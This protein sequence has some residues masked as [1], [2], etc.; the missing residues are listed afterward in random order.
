MK[1]T[2]GLGLILGFLFTI[3]SIV[4]SAKTSNN[5]TPITEGQQIKTLI[6]NANVSI[7]L[8]AN[9]KSSLEVIGGNYIKKHIS[10][11]QNGDTLVIGSTRNKNLKNS[12][13]IYVPASFLQN[14]LINSESQIRTLYSLQI[15][16]LDVVINGVCDFAISN[17]GEVN[18]IE[19]DK[20][21]Y[22]QTTTI[23]RLPGTA[24]FNQ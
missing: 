17:I 23:R 24:V 3:V 6:I 1:K 20:Y 21:T 13:V 19:T 5:E 16:K 9:S 15:P 7:V 8:V 2:Y 22:E 14:I 10:F 4:A 11:K 18:L 12:G